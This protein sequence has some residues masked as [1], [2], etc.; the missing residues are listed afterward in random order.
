MLLL[1]AREALGH[2]LPTKLDNSEILRRRVNRMTNVGR[3]LV[4]G[5]VGR[6]REP[7]H[8][9]LHVCYR[10]N[11]EDH[12]S[13]TG[14]RAAALFRA[15]VQRTPALSERKPRVTRQRQTLRPQ[16]E[17]QPLRDVTRKNE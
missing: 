11:I 8:S 10:G 9:R 14:L 17:F 12:M 5:G 7:T 3:E 13:C 6:V 15:F 16:I 4:C 1:K 2:L